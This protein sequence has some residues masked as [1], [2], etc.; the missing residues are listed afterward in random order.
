[1]DTAPSFILSAWKSSVIISAGF[2]LLYTLLLKTQHTLGTYKDKLYCIFVTIHLSVSNVGKKMLHGQ[3]KTL[4]ELCGYFCAKRVADDPF[5]V[6]LVKVEVR[7]INC[8][9]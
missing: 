5:C 3:K 8:S 2:M 1:M 9:V 6:T 4:M 7:S